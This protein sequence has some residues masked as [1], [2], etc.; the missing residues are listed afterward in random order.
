MRQAADLGSMQ[1]GVPHDGYRRGAEQSRQ[2]ETEARAGSNNV[3]TGKN[4]T[5]LLCGVD[6]RQR[7]IWLGFSEVMVQSRLSA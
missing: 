4:S 2:Q 6:K 1:G 5:E 3:S 7:V